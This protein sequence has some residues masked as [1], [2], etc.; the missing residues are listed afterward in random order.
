M[1]SRSRTQRA[2]KSVGI[3]ASQSWPTWAPAS[4]SPSTQPS[5]CSSAAT[6]STSSLA[7]VTPKRVVE[8]VG[9]RDV[10]ARRRTGRCPRSRRELDDRS[11]LQLGI[12]AA[13]A[14]GERRPSARRRTRRRGSRARAR[15]APRR[16]GVQAARR[17][18][19]AASAT[20]A[21]AGTIVNDVGS[22]IVMRNAT[23]RQV[24]CG[25]TSAP[26]RECRPV[27]R[28]LV[29]PPRLGLARSRGRRGSPTT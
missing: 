20:R 14:D 4:E 10:A 26:R 12:G 2:R 18:A 21:N 9:E 7:N 27:A 13:L 29:G 11:A 23:G 1:S 5:A 17:A 24:T 19:S 28:D 6:P 16:V 3:A 22:A 15:R 8:V 25:W